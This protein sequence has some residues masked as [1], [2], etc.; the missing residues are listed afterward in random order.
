MIQYIVIVGAIVQLYGISSYIKETL[1]GNTKPN[2]MTWL[3]WSIA[4]LIGVT[5]AIVDGVSLLAVLPVF[6]AGFG[7]FLVFIVSFINKN[8]YWKLEKF[9]YLCGF[10]SI[11]SLVIWWLTKQPVIAIIF[12]IISDALAATPTIIKSRLHPE[13]E[14]VDPFVAGAF[15]AATSFFAIKYWTLSAILFPLYLICV[16][17]TLVTMAYK[18]RSKN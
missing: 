18:H 6:M 15:S 12:A 5:A 14:T 11:I 3:L 8:S 4:P 10:F 13:T 9:D 2:R 1:L 16:N 7:P 17:S